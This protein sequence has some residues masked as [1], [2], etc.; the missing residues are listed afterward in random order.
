MLKNNLNFKSKITS[1]F[2]ILAALL[3][4]GLVLVFD[5]SKSNAKDE[6]NN[7]Q[8]A[9]E[10]RP[11]TPAG[12][13]LKDSTTNLTA[14]GALPCNFVRSP[15]KLGTD[16]KGRYLLAINSG[17]GIQFDAESNRG[18]QSIAVIDLNLK[19]VP[20]IVQNVYFPTPQSVSF[21]VRFH[22]AADPDGSF[23]LYA[24]GGFENK[25]WVFKFSPDEIK[26]ISPA[27]DGKKDKQGNETGVTAPFIDVSA[28]TA[29]APSPNY[30]DNT[31]AVY[32]T[33]IAL[34]PDDETLFTANNLGD[35]L[36]IISDLRDSR[37][38]SRV[39]LQ[40]PGSKQFVYP[41]DVEVIPDKEGKNTAKAY[42]SLWGDGSVAVVDL[43]KR[44]K[45]SHI[46]TDRHPTAM[47][48]NNAKTR[49][50]VVNSN[51]DSVSVIDTKTD[52]IVERISLKLAES[53][54]IGS[55]PEG[56][57]LSD[58][59]KT[60]YV[61]DAHANAVAVV[62]LGSLTNSRFEIQDSKFKIQNSKFESEDA[63]YK[64]PESKIQNPK[65][66]ILGFIPTGQYASAVAVV[67]GNLF[68][69][70]GKGT[71]VENSSIIVNNSGRVPNAPNA[72]F[73]PK[74][75]NQGGQY[76]GSIVVGNISLI[77]IPGEKQL[78][79]Y[80]QA[81][82]QNNGLIGTRKTALFNGRSPIKHIIYVIK[83]NRTYDQ[84]FGDLKKSGDG[85]GAD[86]DAGLAIFGAGQT[87]ASP[88]GEPQNIT[89][90]LRALALRFGLLDRF[91]V[92]AEASP[93]GHNW[94]TAAF[95]NDY[96]DK[97]FRWNYS[98]RGRTYD[99]EGFNRLPSFNPPANQPP[100][101]LPPVFDLPATEN[102]IAGYLKRYVPYLSGGRDIGEP[103]T[104]YLWDAAQRANLTYRNY[105]E[106]VATVSAADVKEV[107]TRQAKKYPDITPTKT[108]F[109]VKKTLEG[110]F[111]DTVRNFDMDTPDSFTTDSYRA[112]VESKEAVDA[113]ISPD[114]SDQKFRGSSRFGDWQQEFRGIVNDFNAGRGDKLPNLSI[115]R[116]SNDHTAGL[117][118][119]TPTPQFYVAENDYAVGRLVEEVSNSPYWKDT[120]IFVVEDDAQ[121]GPDHVDAHRS[122][123]FVISAY[124][125][126]GVLIHDFHNTVSLI[127]T[128]EIL[129]GIKPMNLLD[130]TA[131]PI[132]IF[133]SS[134][135]LAPYKAVLPTVALDNLFPP[136]K[137]SA[138]LREMMDLTADQNLSHQDMANPE[139]LNR[140]IWFSVRG[141][142][143]KMPDVVQLPA[144]D[145]MT[146]GLKEDVEDEEN[147]SE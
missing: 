76:S 29:N 132:D 75:K 96:I 77:H 16:G 113:L 122:P 39:N 10:G 140:I 136:K 94:S 2:T 24:A 135:D 115:L 141:E 22:P 20:K 9:S 66:K 86:G 65:S 41:F 48:L 108:A 34:S 74:E 67:G 138:A 27:S 78:F 79:N 31:A 28:L 137:V 84:V 103:E 12:E 47:I 95:S 53:E 110:H 7:N 4:G 143:V 109:A 58:D 49:L 83:E 116:L 54:P 106:Y 43:L 107:N 23:R 68:V 121:A 85:S 99:F 35:T 118:Q 119:G 13:L 134:P 102:D 26:P 71:G 93:D 139:E 46:L 147:K 144:F 80:T 145:L 59:E 50:F 19:P 100:V 14:V 37:K 142:S 61:A 8:T 56:L 69:G 1:L 52:R 55:S 82:M 33:G 88:T 30:N 18:E 11:I 105:G 124:N 146:A 128:M 133:Q 97:S 6:K 72:A 131:S 90:N 5:A 60:L 98:G 70:N 64:N 120:A 63:G 81:V 123:A 21:G 117:R 111:S 112:A 15:D 104:L 45:V 129:L 73:P 130:A 36:G 17:F 44:N 127:R 126:K 25:V 57:A 40:R 101:A 62:E 114:H 89:P 87:A 51:A 3:V 92:N 38:I 32:P 91:F 125:R 42:I